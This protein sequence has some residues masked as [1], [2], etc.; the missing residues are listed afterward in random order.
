[1]TALDINMLLRDYYKQYQS[2][3]QYPRNKDLNYVHASSLVHTPCARKL[4]YEYFHQ[5]VSFRMTKSAYSSNI[6]AIGSALEQDRINTWTQKPIIGPNGKELMFLGSWKCHCAINGSQKGLIV[7]GV[8]SI[9]DSRFNVPCSTCGTP[10]MYYD[11]YQ[12]Y[13][14]SI[15]ISG[16]PDLVIVSVG[17]DNTL[18][19]YEI[20]TVMKSDF[21]KIKD[22]KSVKTVDHIKQSCMYYYFFKDLLKESPISY[23]DSEGDK[24]EITDISKEI[25]IL[26]IDKRDDKAKYA[27]PDHPDISILSR[28]WMLGDSNWFYIYNVDGVPVDESAMKADNGSWM[29]KEDQLA[30]EGDGSLVENY[31]VKRDDQY[32]FRPLQYMKFASKVSKKA[33][34][35]KKASTLPSREESF[36][37]CLGKR[38]TTQILKSSAERCDCPYHYLCSKDRLY[39]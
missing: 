34:E 12:F 7:K 1:M 18:Y 3:P 37:P 11:E 14:R 26:Y 20:K 8:R 32:Y 22:K 28:D 10:A 2:R 17:D 36:L 30:Y 6:F 31:I 4:V 23:I 5:S 29:N 16:R 19:L 9:H 15:G 38:D 35:H 39:E 33:M 21:I 27:A 25:T 24:K 13:V